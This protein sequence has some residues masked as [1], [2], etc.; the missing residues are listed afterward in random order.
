MGKLDF[1]FHSM[2]FVPT[3]PGMTGIDCAA[4][5]LSGGTGYILPFF[6]RLAKCAAPLMVMAA[7]F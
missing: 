2:A 3:G 4:H 7:C 5:R 6:S 1:L